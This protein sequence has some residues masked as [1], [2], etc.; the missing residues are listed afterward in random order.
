[1]DTKKIYWMSWEKLCVPKEKGG[2]EIK[3]LY[4]YNLALLNKQGWRVVQP[5]QLF[6]MQQR[7]PIALVVGEY[8][9]SK[10]CFRGWTFTVVY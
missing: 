1:M 6:G 10:V 3:D 5:L 2:M 9:T 7:N 8:R 4:A